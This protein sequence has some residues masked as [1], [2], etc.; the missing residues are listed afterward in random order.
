MRLQGLRRGQVLKNIDTTLAKMV[1]LS[2]N[3]IKSEEI[4]RTLKILDD[5]EFPNALVKRL[6]SQP[7]QLNAV[8]GRLCSLQRDC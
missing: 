7:A 6:F 3:G 4:K 8:H 5:E 2:A 1:E